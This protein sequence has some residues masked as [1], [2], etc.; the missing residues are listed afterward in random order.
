VLKEAKALLAKGDVDGA[1]ERARAIPESSNLRA[2]P[3]FRAIQDTW[4]D[5]LFA[6]A[7]KAQDPS[8]KRALLDQIASTPSV[9]AARRKRAADELEAM[10]RSAVNIADLPSDVEVEGDAGTATE[11]DV[12]EDVAPAA[13]EKQAPPGA[14]KASTAKKTPAPAPKPAQTSGSL[15]RKNPFGGP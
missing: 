15:V 6:K 14:A 11:V 2:S 12:E 13:S 10:Q 9:G 1:M 3:D 5:A 7:E 4:A 8:E